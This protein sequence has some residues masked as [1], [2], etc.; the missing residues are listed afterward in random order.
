MAISEPVS[1]FASAGGAKL[2]FET[3]GVGDALVFIH[4]GVA[5]RRMWDPQV[6]YFAPRYRVIRYDL[7][8]FGKSEMG[9]GPYSHRDDLLSVLTSLEV[10]KA[11]LIGCS[12]GGT[13]AIDFALEHPQMVTALVPV[14]AGVSGFN[15]SSH[16]SMA[17]WG[18]MMSLL[19]A[20][21]FEQAR[22]LDAHYWIDGPSRDSS[23][24]DPGF[25]KRAVA[26][27]KDN[28]SIERF[29]KPEQELKPPAL[30]RLGEIRCPTL[31]VIGDSDVQDL[32]KLSNRIA[33]EVSGAKLTTIA[34]AAH[35]PSQEHPD[36][37]NRILDEFLT[38]VQ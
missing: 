26:V 29:S 38:S 14:A 1:G 35:L 32:I 15:P 23:R 8:G 24:V 22:E 37:F 18:K 13:T 25:R 30:G 2:Y 7:R 27:H 20:R 33:A 5:D 31:V 34:N 11:A 36:Q 16:E 21:N 6:E 17:H 9:D 19:Q 12:M 10:R 28:F 3:V 4:A